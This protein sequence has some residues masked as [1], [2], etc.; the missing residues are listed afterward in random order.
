MALIGEPKI[1]DG[2]VAILLGH[3]DG[4]FTAP[5]LYPVGN[6]NA[7]RLIATDLNHDGKLDLAVA[8]KHGTR[9]KDGL[10]VLLGNGDGTFQPVVTS[11]SGVNG[12]DVAAADFNGD[13]NVDLAVA[14]P[15]EGTIEV[16]LGNGDGTFQP[17]T[18]YSAGGPDN[19]NLPRHGERRGHEWRWFPRSGAGQQSQCDPAGETELA[20]SHRR[21]FI[22]LVG[23]LR[24]PVIL[25]ATKS[26][27]S[28]G[29]LSTCDPVSPTL[30]S[31]LAGPWDDYCSAGVF[32]RRIQYRTTLRHRRGG[33][34]RRW[35]PRP[36]RR[37]LPDLFPP[38]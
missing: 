20:A 31:P 2:Q 18:A 4:T 15:A 24:G 11:V 26:L 10:G 29:R 17:V 1:F 22:A 21:L 25:I 16:V 13:G 9:G 32:G 30:L 14:V 6:Q 36:H 33:F 23:V 28:S 34:R 7:A 8:L 12:T 35:I 5:V 3:G 38:W 27:I 37:R 19:Y